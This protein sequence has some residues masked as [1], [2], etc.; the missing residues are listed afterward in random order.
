MKF[1]ARVPARYLKRVLVV[2]L[3]IAVFAS[4]W[5][6]VA[7]A[8]HLETSETSGILWWK[9]SR[10]VP[11]AER[12]PSLIAAVLLLFLVALCLVVAATMALHLWRTRDERQAENLAAEARRLADEERQAEAAAHAAWVLTDQGRAWAAHRSGEREFAVTLRIQPPDH[13]ET[14]REIES[15]GWVLRGRD[16]HAEVRV[17]ESRRNLDGGHTVV[18]TVT[19]DATFYFE[20]GRPGAA[21]NY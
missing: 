2:S 12:R 11:L 9:E 19:K 3:W 14:I 7:F 5:A 15:V 16:D 17:K 1:L 18:T 4:L 21:A 20:R 8:D 13:R 10:A 6:T